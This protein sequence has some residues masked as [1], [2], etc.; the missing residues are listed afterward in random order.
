MFATHNKELGFLFGTSKMPLR[1]EKGFA[2]SSVDQS[3]F[4]FPQFWLAQAGERSG[5]MMPLALCE[6]LCHRCVL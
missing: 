5:I 6:D 2:F 3:E 1:F 4:K